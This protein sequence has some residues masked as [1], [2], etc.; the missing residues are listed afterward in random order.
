MG[1]R[2]EERERVR[3]GGE[4]EL[5]SLSSNGLLLGF[6]AKHLISQSLAVMT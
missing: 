6:N 2:G 1:G 5:L 4:R 3:E